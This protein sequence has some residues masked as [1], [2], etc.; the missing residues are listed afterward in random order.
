TFC[1]IEL[2]RAARSVDDAFE[3]ARRQSLRPICPF[4]TLEGDR[5]VIAMPGDP[6]HPDPD[7]EGIDPNAPTR[8]V[9]EDG[10]LVARTVQRPSR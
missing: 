2:L 10:R 8:F 6:L 3:I 1:T 5:M 9:L 4:A 7:A